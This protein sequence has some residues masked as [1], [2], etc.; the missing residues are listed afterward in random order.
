MSLLY[1]Q[2]GSVIYTF[3]LNNTL[4]DSSAVFSSD[5]GCHLGEHSMWGKVTLLEACARVPLVVR[6]PGVSKTGT[7]S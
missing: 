5:Y 3:T 4:V 6:V 2:M 1:D 7:R